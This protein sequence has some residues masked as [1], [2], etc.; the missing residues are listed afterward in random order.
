MGI[1]SRSAAV[2]MATAGGLGFRVAAGSRHWAYVIRDLR[3][4]SA[5]VVGTF[6]AGDIGGLSHRW[7]GDERCR[8]SGYEHPVAD[9]VCFSP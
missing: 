8:C 9:H 2:V 7:A 5:A 6:V 1:G 4:W 3:L